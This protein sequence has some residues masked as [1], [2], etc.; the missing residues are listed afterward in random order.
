[1]LQAEPPRRDG[2]Q[3]NGG[4][5]EPTPVQCLDFLPAAWR[6][7]AQPSNPFF[8]IYLHEI[9]KIPILRYVTS[10]AHLNQTEPR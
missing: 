10:K 3:A 9:S 5:R 1:M 8:L 6:A 2:P 4:E 7:F